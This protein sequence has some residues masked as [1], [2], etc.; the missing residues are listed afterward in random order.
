[1]P[2]PGQLGVVEDLL[3]DRAFVAD[4]QA[5]AEELASLADVRPFAPHNRFD[6]SRRSAV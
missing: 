1:V 3:V 4:P 5:S 2:A 6:R